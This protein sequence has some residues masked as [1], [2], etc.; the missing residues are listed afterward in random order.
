MKPLWKFYNKGNGE[1]I[2]SSGGI[3]SRSF[4]PVIK[5][6]HLNVPVAFLAWK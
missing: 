1:G 4:N 5:N 3:F 6:D 2:W